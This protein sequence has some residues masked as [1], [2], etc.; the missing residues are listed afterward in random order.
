MIADHTR[1]YPPGSSATGRVAAEHQAAGA[2][3][4]DRELDRT[5]GCRP[6]S[7][8]R[9]AGRGPTPWRTRAG[10]S[11]AARSS[12]GRTAP[13]RRGT[14]E[15]AGRARA[16]SSTCAAP[17]TRSDSTGTCA[18]CLDAARDALV[19]RHGPRGAFQHRAAP[20]S[21]SGRSSRSSGPA[22]GCSD[23]RSVG[24]LAREPE[25]LRSERRQVHRRRAAGPRLPAIG[26]PRPSP[27]CPRGQSSA[28]TSTAL[29]HPGGGRSRGEQP[30][31][32]ERL[33]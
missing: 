21:T 29:I 31:K 32:P 2:E 16:W 22:I 24:G 5:G 25:H 26:G 3:Q 1:W 23:Q 7:T 19:E 12:V 8:R 9:A 28:W 27:R 10:R 33:A 4:L 13:S 17:D 30:A 6:R 15:T 18:R 20:S 11:A 14:S